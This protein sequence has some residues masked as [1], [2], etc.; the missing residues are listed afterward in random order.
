VLETWCIN[1]HRSEQRRNMHAT[2]AVVGMTIRIRMTWRGR[3][4]RVRMMLLM[5]TGCSAIMRHI[6]RIDN[7][8]EA[9]SKQAQ[10]DQSCNRVPHCIDRLRTRTGLQATES[11]CRS[12]GGAT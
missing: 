7:A 11:T 3:F 2:V 9:R 4:M 12:A 8:F 5:Q 10:D 1:R 6:H